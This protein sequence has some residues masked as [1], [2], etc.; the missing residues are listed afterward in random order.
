MTAVDAER[1]TSRRSPRPAPYRPP[2]PAAGTGLKGEYFDNANFTGLK[3]T[4]IDA[5][6]NFDWSTGS[7][8]ASIGVDTFSVRWTG[9]IRRRRPAATRSRSAPTTACACGSTACS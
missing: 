9:Q 1:A 3:L 4:R 6:I 7:P 2:A 8:D 5:A